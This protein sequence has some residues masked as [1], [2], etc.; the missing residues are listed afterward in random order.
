MKVNFLNA[1]HWQLFSLMY[2]MPVL[3]IFWITGQN[4]D[5]AYNSLEKVVTILF[6][7]INLFI[8]FG[9]IWQLTQTF[10]K[11]PFSASS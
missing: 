8:L 7:L 5:S 3:F 4:T 9:W 1:R 6:S 2:L 10:G 11:N